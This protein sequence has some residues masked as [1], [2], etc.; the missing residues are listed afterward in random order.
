MDSPC[1]AL[2][3]TSRP[4]VQRKWLDVHRPHGQGELPTI[5]TLRLP[6]QSTMVLQCLRQF[7]QGV[8]GQAEPATQLVLP[9]FDRLRQ[10]PKR[11]PKSQGG[12][13]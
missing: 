2:T 9:H 4:E 8:A 3:H 1:G 6:I 7:V 11:N 12:Y 13:G 5:I 10:R